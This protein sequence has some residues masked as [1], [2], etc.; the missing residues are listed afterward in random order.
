MMLRFLTV[1]AL[2]L[3]AASFIIQCATVPACREVSREAFTIGW[4]LFST[5][6]TT[7]ECDTDS[8]CMARCGGDGSPE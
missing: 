6:T 5:T 1:L 3:L 4:G 2:A 7:C 8:D